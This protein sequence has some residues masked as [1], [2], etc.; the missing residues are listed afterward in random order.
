MGQI[1]YSTCDNQHALLIFNYFLKILFGHG[2]TLQ[3]N[4]ANSY[5]YT[6]TTLLFFFMCNISTYSVFLISYHRELL[7]LI[8]VSDEYIG[9]LITNM[10]SFLFYF[11]LLVF[12]I[13]M[14][15]YMFGGSRA[16]IQQNHFG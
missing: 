6:F 10:N 8:F 16:M 5:I 14:D 13:I 11:K 7:K 4:I 3:S 12:R 9:V 2:R 15:V 1:F